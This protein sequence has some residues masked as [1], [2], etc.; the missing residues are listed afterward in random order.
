[1]MQTQAGRHPRHGWLRNRLFVTLAIIGMVA[2]G[3]VVAQSNDVAWA[4]DYPSWN[5][6]LKARNNVKAKQAQIT[7]IQGIIKQLEVQVANTEA[8]AK[9][10]GEEFQKAVEA[11]DAQD[12]KTQEYQRQADDAL[13]QADI[14]KKRAGQLAARLSRTGGSDLTATLFFNG[15]DATDLLSQLGMA[16]KI[17]EQSH[18][19]Y[20]KAIQQQ[21]TAQ[22]LTDQANVARSALA[23]LK[24]AAE[25]AQQAAQAAADS[26]AA[27]FAEQQKNN[28][29][30]QA[31]LAT[32]K[33]NKIHTE[34]EY[35]K[36]VQAQWGAGG[37]VEISSQGWARPASGHVTSGYGAR[38][39]PTGGVSPFHR[40]TDI[41][42]SCNS[43]IYAAH[44]GTVSYAGWY[45]TY[46]NFIL[47]QHEGGVS[48]GYAHIVNGGILVHSG[49]TVGVGH[50]IARVGSTGASTGCHLHFEVRVNGSA[51]DAV[52]FMRARGINIS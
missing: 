2:T 52:P 12:Q 15:D 27:A 34:A 7:R 23:E 39:P 45:G 8:I 10:K 42:A 5:D 51:I 30:L 17:T 49:Q 33:S 28:A 35:V 37:A 21:N 32:L 3:S 41:G 19:L 43:P 44:T 29:T 4:K 16:S 9:K 47:I 31:Q 48:T 50:Q 1:M 24:V 18:G 38:V 13:E 14:L 11:Y 25:K 20:D 36:G 22:S 40:G 6:V 26:A 46:G